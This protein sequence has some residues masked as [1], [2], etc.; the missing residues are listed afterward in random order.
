MTFWDE[1]GN[2]VGNA[3]GWNQAQAAQQARD[4][5]AQAVQ[6]QMNLAGGAAG[7]AANMLGSFQQSMGANA[8]QTIQNA[9]NAAMPVARQIAGMT[10]NVSGRQTLSAARTA[11]LNKGQAALEG[12][13]MAGNATQAAMPGAIQQQIGN[14]LGAAGQFGAMQGQLQGQALQGY[15]QAGQT[16]ERMANPQGEQGRK[17]F[18]LG[19]GML[20]SG[21]GAFGTPAGAGSAALAGAAQ[22][23]IVESPTVAGEAGPEIVIPVRK[24]F[25]KKRTL[26]EIIKVIRPEVE[27]TTEAHPD[28]KADP[29][30]S[31]L[32]KRIEAIE[33]R[34]QGEKTS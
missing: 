11:G 12:G 26:E 20:G 30:V 8:G 3:L 13:Q 5:E 7:G 1:L 4:Q 25:K 27:K 34:Y 18:G 9:T 31:D 17:G 21:I 10:G 33:S 14:Y 24:I 19:M 16:A 23:G 6:Q 15:G 32:R 28:E 2:W 22:G 29:S